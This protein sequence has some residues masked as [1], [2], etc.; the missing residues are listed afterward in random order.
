[1]GDGQTLTITRLP[2][3]T[4]QTVHTLTPAAYAAATQESAAGPAEKSA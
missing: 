1:M 2:L 3:A 4:N